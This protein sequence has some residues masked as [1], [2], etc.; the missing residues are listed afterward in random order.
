MAAAVVIGV[1]AALTVVLPLLTA[2]ASAQ[3][4]VGWC[5]ADRLLLSAASGPHTE[6]AQAGGALLWFLQLRHQGHSTCMVENR[7]ALISARTISGEAIKLRAVDGYVF[8]PR[9][10]PLR[11]R[12]T[13]RAFVS[14]WDPA[15]WTRTPIKGCRDRVLLTF[16]LPHRGG[17]L[18]ARP[19]D[20]VAMCPTGSLSI[21]ATFSAATFARFIRQSSST[22]GTVPYA[23]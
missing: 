14:L 19:P 21:S 17:E 23:R 5:Q 9:R 2:R 6:Q 22:P 20:G 7:L 3:D 4:K 1:L 15:T 10:E 12:G 11:V 13:E 18:S 8:G 16:R